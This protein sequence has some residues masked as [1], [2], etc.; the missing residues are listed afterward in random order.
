MLIVG[1]GNPGKEYLG[2]RHNVGFRIID[3]FREEN[4]FSD[5][6]LLKKANSLISRGEIDLQEIVL[7]KPQTFMNNSGTAVKLIINQFSNRDLIVIHDD[8]DLPLGKIK[9]SEGRGSAGHKGVESIIR[10]LKTKDFFRIRIGIQPERGKPKNIDN[11]VLKNFTKNEE[12]ILKQTVKESC[13][14][15]KTII[16]EETRKTIGEVDRSGNKSNS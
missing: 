3:K 5:F 2:T 7:I 6:E 16:K 15:L 4:F 1:L 12:E 11:F 13:I 8:I 10:E 14:A 9:V